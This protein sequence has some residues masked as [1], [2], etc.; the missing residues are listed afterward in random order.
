L[1]YVRPYTKILIIAI[2]G[3]IVK[4]TVPLLLPKLTQIL[5]DD[6]FL[7]ETLT[8]E[9]KLYDLFF[10]IG[11]MVGIFLLVYA[12][13]VYVRHLYAGKAGCCA[14]FDLRC[15]LYHRV[16]RMSTSFFNR[17]KSGEIVSRLISDIQLA[18]NLVGNAL[19]NIWMDATA[20][21]VVFYFLF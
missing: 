16:L 6:V 8:N 11:G 3:G 21:I 4:F 20:V 1:G 13:S 14:V 9:E 19:T 12:P 5:L 7:N 10:Y 2:I 15:D 18:Q 17:N